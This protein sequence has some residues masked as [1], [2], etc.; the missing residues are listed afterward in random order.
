M[1]STIFPNSY[2]GRSADVFLHQ[3]SRDDLKI[4][5][6]AQIVKHII[7]SPTE[8]RMVVIFRSL[9][10]MLDNFDTS[11]NRYHAMMLYY[12]T[13]KNVLSNI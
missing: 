4:I 6:S 2:F 1:Q 13:S 11:T 9:Y 3:S 5:R 7:Y 12:V 10:V 8:S